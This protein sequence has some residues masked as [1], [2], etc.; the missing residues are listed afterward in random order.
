MTSIASLH[1]RGFRFSTRRAK[2]SLGRRAEYRGGN[3]R[4]SRLHGRARDWCRRGRR[5]C[6]I[7]RGHVSVQTGQKRLGQCGRLQ[8]CWLSRAGAGRSRRNGGLW[9][10]QDAVCWCRVCGRLAHLW[11]TRRRWDSVC[12]LQERGVNR[13]RTFRVRMEEFNILQSLLSR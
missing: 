6:G 13:R 2:E 11:I 1:T 12:A 8:V 5:Q 4:K 10:R 3:R 7:R 9:W